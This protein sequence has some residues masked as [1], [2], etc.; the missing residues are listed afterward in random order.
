MHHL[1]QKFS[2]SNFLSLLYYRRPVP[3]RP[4]EILCCKVSY[5]AFCSLLC[6][7]ICLLG[8]SF[9]LYSAEYNLSERSFFLKTNGQTNKKF[10]R[11]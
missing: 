4:C 3:P 5:L 2:V 11:N 10:A 6:Y 9:L 1:Q 7:T 8:T